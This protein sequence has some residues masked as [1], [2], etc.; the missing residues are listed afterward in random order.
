M[1]S[2]Y[3][4]YSFYRPNYKLL[5]EDT[6]I[7]LTWILFIIRNQTTVKRLISLAQVLSLSLQS[8][9]NGLYNI[10][11]I[12]PYS[13]SSTDSLQ[14]NSLLLYAL[15]G[16]AVLNPLPHDPV[17]FIFNPY[18]RDYTAE[19]CKNKWTSEQIHNAPLQSEY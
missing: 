6:K 11:N 5:R 3:C 9:N 7:S 17:P 10:Y 16:S 18:F 19:H 4:T 13:N 2:Q 14:S 8:N 12:I 15:S 1:I